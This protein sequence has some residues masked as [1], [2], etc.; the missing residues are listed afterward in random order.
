MIDKSVRTSFEN[1][2]ALQAW[3]ETIEQEIKEIT[4]EI[5]PLQQQLDAAR[6]K[7]DLVRR[8]IHLSTSKVVSPEGNVDTT[9][10]PLQPVTLPGIEDHIEKVLRSQGKPVHI[11]E[12]RASLIKMG[13]PLPGRGD[14]A[15]II[16][17]LRRANDRFIRTGRGTYALTEWNM[18]EYSPVPIK[19]T[20]RK[21]K[22]ATS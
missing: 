5:L 21:Q 7:L 19:K 3:T 17:R 22:K 18:P 20:V 12:I 8:L 10:S 2:E 9:P 16:L 13:V 15:N 14:E 1:I 4:S 11:S 6:E